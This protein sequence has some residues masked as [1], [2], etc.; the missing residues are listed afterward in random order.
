MTSATVTLTTEQIDELG[1]ELDALKQRVV[2]DLGQEDRD[3]IYNVIKAQRALE[4][5]G[6]ASFY[7]GFLPPFWLAGVAALSLSKILDN[8][9]IGHNVMHGQYDWMRDPA[10]NSKMFEW[11]TACPSDQWRHSHNYMHHTY[12]NILGKDRDIGYGLLRMDESQKWNPYYLGNPVYAFALMTFFQ[13]GVALHDLEAEN[14]V[15]GRRKMSENRALLNGIWRKIGKQTLKD[16]VLFPALTGPLFVSTLAGN[17]TANLVRNVWA[18]SIIFCGHFPSGVATF[19]EEE[20]ADESRGAWYV[21]QM[22]GSANITGSKL[23]HVLSGN[24]SHQIEHHLFPDIPARRY[25]QIAAEV[26]A[27]CEKYGLPYNTGRFSKQIGSTWAKIFRL[28]LPF[29]TRGQKDT[30]PAVTVVPKKVP[31]AA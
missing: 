30:P 13:Y 17:A 2:G 26:Q 19:T 4:V 28:A 7:L 10:L 3:Y 1:R 24:L 22:M 8:M 31:V 9:E 25:P 14:L 20:T 5:A 23:F 11:D 21:R 16:Y 27:L 12:T 15:T 18:Y 29:G 6:R